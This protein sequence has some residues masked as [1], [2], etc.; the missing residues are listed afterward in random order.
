MT[1]RPSWILAILIAACATGP[2]GE[3][4][5]TGV[6][7]NISGDRILVEENPQQSAGSAKASVRIT[8]KTEIRSSSG[9]TATR[10]D[11]RVGDQVRVWFTGPVMESYPVQATAARIETSR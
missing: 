4:S 10:G 3:P 9:G 1:K 5:I 2:V 8:E 7:T 6:V 11:L